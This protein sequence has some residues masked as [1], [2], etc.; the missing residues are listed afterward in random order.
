MAV[1]LSDA[2]LQAR[3]RAQ[4]QGRPLSSAE[5][6]GITSGWADSASTRLARAR[7]LGIQEKGLT[8]DEQRI[9]E[10]KRA[11]QA[12]EATANRAISEQMNAANKASKYGMVRDA[13]NL[14]ATGYMG[15]KYFNPSGP[16]A[17]DNTW[18]ANQFELP[19][20]SPSPATP[21]ADQGANIAGAAAGGAVGGSVAPSLAKWGTTDPLNMNTQEFGQVW[22]DNLLSSGGDMFEGGTLAGGGGSEGGAGAVGVL[23]GAGEYG[24]QG[25]VG[26]GIGEMGATLGPV[27]GIWQAMLG[28]AALGTLGI[29]GIKALRKAMG[30]EGKQLSEYST[31]ELIDTYTKGAGSAGSLPVYQELQRRGV[32]GLTPMSN[33][34]VNQYYK[35]VGT[36]SFDEDGKLVQRFDWA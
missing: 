35:D 5:M 26:T 17:T 14:G 12:Q 13:A 18:V 22:G 16:S 23:E 34:A 1:N 19:G 36:M 8:L 10:Q 29:A 21:V 27:P 32:S 31:Q 7:Q 20:S 33:Q 9:A 15:Y 30:Q 24:A 4:L 3:R 11:N 2:L 6:G 28:T 25:G